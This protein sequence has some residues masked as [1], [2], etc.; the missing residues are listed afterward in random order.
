M[1]YVPTQ[2]DYDLLF[3]QST[4]L[5]VR[6]DICNKNGTVVAS[7]T[8]IKSNVNYSIDGTSNS[9]RQFSGTLN[10]S[11]LQSLSVNNNGLVWMDKDVYLYIGFY[12]YSNSDWIWYPC[13]KYI[14]TTA[15]TTCNNTT[16]ELKFSTIDYWG[17]LDGTKYGTLGNFIKG[18]IEAY[19]KDEN[20]FKIAGTEVSIKKGIENVINLSNIKEYMVE[21]IGE[22]AGTYKSDNYQSYRENNVNWDK[23][24]YDIEFDNSITVAEMLNKLVTLYPN[25]DAYF[26]NEGILKVGILP[27]NDNENSILTDEQIRKI[28]L[29]DSGQ[30]INYDLTTI[31]NIVYCV[32]ESYDSDYY[33]KSENVTYSLEDESIDSYRVYNK[34]YKREDWDTTGNGYYDGDIITFIAP[35][36]NVKN[37]VS[38]QMSNDSDTFSSIIV[39]DCYTG[40]PIGTNRLIE[41][42]TYSFKVSKIINADKTVTTKIYLLGSYQPNGM[43]VCTDDVTINPYIGS[44]NIE[45]TDYESLRNYF[46]K[47]YNVDNVK[48]MILKDS[49][50]TIQKL[51]ECAMKYEPD[52][53]VI[54]ESDSDAVGTSEYVLWQKVRL[55]ET[56]TLTTKLIPWLS[57]NDII[58]FKPEGIDNI[59]KYIVKQI[60]NTIDD[61]NCSS[62]ITMYKYYPLYREEELDYI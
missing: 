27:S 25:N 22:Y 21:D 1:A 56:V 10:P 39:C 29:G 3:K 54:I 17:K 49:P 4:K 48:F 45:C 51:G 15:D 20:G 18:A 26:D 59:N 36:T 61:N 33:V 5:C 34:Y 53:N 55:T 31:K 42:H 35:K 62:T 32:G 37:K 9:R 14:F 7:L 23:I 40:E 13:G 46:K 30:Q 28:I 8:D 12:D 16:Y 52:G 60:N 44:D 41:G 57:D 58:E 47:T 43:T 6:L 2:R 11:N 38:I 19:S 24:P 50:F